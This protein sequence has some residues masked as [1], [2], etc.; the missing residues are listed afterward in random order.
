LCSRAGKGTDHF[1]TLGIERKFALDEAALKADYLRLMAAHHPDRHT[2]GSSVEQSGSAD[3]SADVTRAFSVLSRRHSRAVHLLELLGVPLMEETNGAALLGPDFLSE[4]ME[5]RFEVDGP[6]TT[7]TRLKQ[8]RKEN[9]QLMRDIHVELAEAFARVG[10]VGDGFRS[11]VGDGSGGV[12]ADLEAARVL[13]AKL[14]YLKRI[15][16]VA[17][18]RLEREEERS[19]T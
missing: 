2:R 16:D 18:D 15:D 3:R 12:S 1:A 9:E 19:A 8:L 6:D 17:A 13:T 7:A 10:R 5:A 11:A 14:G 4:V